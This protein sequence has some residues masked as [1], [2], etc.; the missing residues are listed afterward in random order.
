MCAYITCTKLI[1][2]STVNIC[3]KLKS[4]RRGEEQS[5]PS[6]DKQNKRRTISSIKDPSS[7][8]CESVGNI[9][10]KPILHISLGQPL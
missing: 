7:R 3:V 4:N 6:K 1:D 2:N 5:F 8:L 9:Y 10:H